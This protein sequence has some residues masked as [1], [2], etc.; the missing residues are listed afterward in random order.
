MLVCVVWD[1]SFEPLLF[2]GLSDERRAAGSADE[3]SLHG[4][5]GYFVLLS[6]CGT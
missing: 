3:G 2:M 4:D 1:G 6:L 5:F